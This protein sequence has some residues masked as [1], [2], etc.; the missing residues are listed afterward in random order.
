MCV[1]VRARSLRRS[2]RNATLVY[3]ALRVGPSELREKR[4]SQHEI[5]IEGWKS[6]RH[7]Q[8]R[9][10]AGGVAEVSGDAS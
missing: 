5:A 6:T 4:V 10:T 8:S 2:G 7:E 3:N 9:G 1:C